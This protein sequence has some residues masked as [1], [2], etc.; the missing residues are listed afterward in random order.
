MFERTYMFTKTTTNNNSIPQLGLMGAAVLT[1]NMIAN[2]V[3]LEAVP[4]DA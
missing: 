2:K 3:Y 1:N 4:E